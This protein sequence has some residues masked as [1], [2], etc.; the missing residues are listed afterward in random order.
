MAEKPEIN[1]SQAIRDYY[2]ANPKAKS[3]EVID[4]LGKKGITVTTGLV[5]NVKSTHNKKHAARKAAK[6]QAAGATTTATKKPG[7]SKTQAVKDFYKANPKASNQEAV[8]ALAKEGITISTNYI[9]NIKSNRKKRRNVVKAA[10]AKGEIGI[11][12]IKAALTFIKS[13]GSVAAAKQAIAAAE[14]IRKIV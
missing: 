4:A 9:S 13:A 2:K 14:E 11:S 5:N 3:S 8:D 7:V 1:R 6:S 10:V 12:E